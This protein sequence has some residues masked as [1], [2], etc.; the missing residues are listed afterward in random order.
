MMTSKDKLAPKEEL[1]MI[2]T[3][4]VNGFSVAS[5]PKHG[6]FYIKHMDNNISSDIDHKRKLYFEKAKKEGLPTTEE[7]EEFLVKEGTWADEEKRKVGELESYVE[8]LKKTQSK[9]VLKKQIDVISNDIREAE[10]E[11]SEL[12]EKRFSLIGLTAEIYSTKK[13]NEHYVFQTVFKDSKLETPL[14]SDE[15]FDE[16]SEEQL[17]SVVVAY[18]GR[19]DRFVDLNLKRIAVS[20][21]YLNNFY[22]CKDN[23]FIFYGKPV[24]NLTYPQSELFSFGRYFKNILTELKH[25]PTEEQLDDPDKLIEMFNVSKNAE[26]VLTEGKA[27]AGKDKVVST[28]VGATKEDLERMGAQNDPGAKDINQIAAEQGG[29]LSMEDLIKLHKM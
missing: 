6:V 22:L 18:N 1:R 3:D 28:V 16:L 26:K 17:G 13:V 21:F 20:G 25:P 11:L 4:V 5:H 29:H 2:Y 23:P 14:F 27:T 9:L 24:V 15:E 7:K 12:M 10:E 19:M 8:N